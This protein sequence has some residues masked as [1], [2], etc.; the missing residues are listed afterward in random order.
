MIGYR[1]GRLEMKDRPSL[2]SSGSPSCFISTALT[3]DGRFSCE[4]K[5]DTKDNS[6]IDACWRFRFHLENETKAW[7][8]RNK[9]L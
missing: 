2:C 1:G 9:A 3:P 4:K 6:F 8:N 5:F 7:H